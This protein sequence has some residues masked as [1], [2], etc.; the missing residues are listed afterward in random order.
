MLVADDE[1]RDLQCAFDHY[2]FSKGIEHGIHKH[3]Q[4]SRREAELA[5]GALQF[6]AQWRVALFGRDF[7]ERRLHQKALF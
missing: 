5:A 7:N 3:N 2:P 6:D 4:Y 1:I